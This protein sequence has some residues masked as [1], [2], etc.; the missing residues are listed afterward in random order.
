MVP[1]VQFCMGWSATKAIAALR[2]MSAGSWMHVVSGKR[3]PNSWVLMEVTTVTL[4][5]EVACR[6]AVS[7]SSIIAHANVAPENGKS[8]KR[9]FASW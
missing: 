8:E 4:W 6:N 9:D 3:S 1:P 5:T 2:P 7:R